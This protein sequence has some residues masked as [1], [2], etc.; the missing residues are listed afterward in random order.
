MSYKPQM[1]TSNNLSAIVRWIFGELT[2]IAN[3]FTSEK[4]NLNLPLTTVDPSKPQVGDIKFA[5][6]SN[7]NPTGQGEGIYLYNTSGNW[8]KIS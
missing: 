7:W 3:T 2:R 1:T 5:D 8:Q 6:G 4:S